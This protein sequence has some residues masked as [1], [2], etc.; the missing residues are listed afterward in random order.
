MRIQYWLIY[1]VMVSAL[2]ILIRFMVYIFTNH[3]P[4]SSWIS[5]IDIVFFGL[6]LNIS[7][8]N[9]LSTFTI[10]KSKKSI[11]QEIRQRIGLFTGISI[12]F[13]ILLAIPLAGFY[14]N[15]IVGTDIINITMAYIGVS[16]MATIS[17][18]FSF[19]VSYCIMRAE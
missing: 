10:R 8:I 16:I 13:I 11:R 5:L 7:N 3:L 15:E 6:T 18:I 19:L 17:L 1:T 9:E 14:I 4:N 2:P 12:L